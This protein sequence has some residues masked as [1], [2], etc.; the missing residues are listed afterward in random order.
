MKTLF[1]LLACC[2]AATAQ[3]GGSYAITSSTLDGGGGSSVG[4]VWKATGT[5]GQPDASTQAATNSG[6]AVAGG[7]WPGLV[8]VPGGPMLTVIPLDAAKVTIAWTAAAVGCQLQYSTDLKSWTD[9]P[10]L[11]ISGAA[12]VVWPLR[13]GPRYYFRLKKP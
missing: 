6:R 5:I 10:G 1:L 13:T 11:T 4:G 8:A 2:T 3:S 7:F 12:S 9:Y